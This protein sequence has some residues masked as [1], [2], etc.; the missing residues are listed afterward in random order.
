MSKR[1]AAF[2]QKAQQDPKY[3]SKKHLAKCAADLR[4]L[5]VNSGQSFKDVADKLRVSPASLSK[6][7]NGN[8]NLTLDSIVAITGAVNSEFDIIFRAQNSSRA[9]QPWEQMIEV[10]NIVSKAEDLVFR[11]EQNLKK[12]E[13]MK[14]TL[15]VMARQAFNRRQ[16]SFSLGKEFHVQCVGSAN[17]EHALLACGS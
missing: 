1:M 11:A 9:Y 16:S 6:K 12:S 17:D 5:I 7:L 2:L 4:L 13:A 10:N 3:R 15:E 14:E 8:T